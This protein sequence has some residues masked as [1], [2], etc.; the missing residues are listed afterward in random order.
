MSEDESIKLYSYFRSSAAYRVR[1]A[2]AIKELP[3]DIIPINLAGGEQSS[4]HY[5]SINPQG[6]VPTL[7][8][9]NLILN[10]SL[11]VIE[12]LDEAYGDYRLLPGNAIARAEVRGLAQQIAMDIHP[13]N[14]LR[15]LKYLQKELNVSEEDKTRWYQHWI[16][17][18][19]T[20]FERTLER[21]QMQN[22]SGDKCKKFVVLESCEGLEGREGLEGGAGKFCWKNTVTLADICLVPQVYNARRF[23]CD[24]A[25]YPLIQSI[26]RHCCR[27]SAFMRAHPES[28]IDS[29]V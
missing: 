8:D 2:L 16:A 22:L 9:K 14:N 13:L 5:L 28:Q 18:G 26:D 29:T 17:E 7:A 25:P 20:A 11:A 24:L 3:V 21:I 6:L 15:V 19:F 27:M 12:Y 23:G 4:D 1:I 10:Q